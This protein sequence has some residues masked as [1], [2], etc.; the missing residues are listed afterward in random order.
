MNIPKF[1]KPIYLAELI[2]IFFKSHFSY[3]RNASLLK[4]QSRPLDGASSVVQE[5]SI[6][7]GK[8]RWKQV[9]ISYWY[10]GKSIDSIDTS[11][12]TQISF[13][14]SPSWTS[15]PQISHLFWCIST[16]GLWIFLNF[17]FFWHLS[18]FYSVFGYFIL[19]IFFGIFC[20]YSSDNTKY[21]Y[22]NKVSIL[23]RTTIL[24]VFGWKCPVLKV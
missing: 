16:C 24:N 15:H 23:F 19:D 1:W 11:I 13:R 12:N 7:D 22:L 2:T 17:L 6:S 4:E 18:R 21:R 3:K 9:S 8:Y 14:K 20:L 5:Y 10:F